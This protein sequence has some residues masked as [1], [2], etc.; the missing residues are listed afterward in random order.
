L[1][2]ISSSGVLSSGTTA[3]CVTVKA[4]ATDESGVSGTKQIAIGDATCNATA[5]AAEEYGTFT[6][7]PNPVQAELRIADEKL[8]S[9]IRIYTLNA[10]LIKTLTVN[11]KEVTV[12]LS[13]YPEGAYL[14]VASYAGSNKK[15]AKVVVKQ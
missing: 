8:I 4:T 15:A 1:A 2:S 6:L 7:S 11:A 14:V 12:D 5:V 13:S 10:M 9:E 3:G